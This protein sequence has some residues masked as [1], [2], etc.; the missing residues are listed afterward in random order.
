M[1]PFQLISVLV[2]LTALFAFLNRRFLRLPATIGVTL[3][4]LA[5][6]LLLLALRD[7][8]L[9]AVQAAQRLLHDLPFDEL[10]FQGLLSFLLFAGALG[11]NTGALLRQ[12]G[13]VLTFALVS[14]LLSV[15][16]VGAL[17]YWLLGLAGMPIPFAAALLFGAI[18]SPTDPV[19]VLDL[20]K[21]AKV[22]R[23]LE[24]LIA[25]ESLFNDGIGVVLFAVLASVALG[26]AGGQAVGGLE[27]L[28]LFAREALGG[29]AF[30]AA[31]GLGAAWLLRQVDDYVVEV[32]VTLAVVTGGYALAGALHVSGPLA[33]VVAGLIVGQVAERG[34]FSD[35]SRPR[36]EGFWHLTDEL[37]NVGLFVLIALEV[38]LVEFSARTLLLGLVCVPIVLFARA[39][40]VRLPLL[41]L[42]RRYAFSPFTSRIM[43]WGGLRG[44]IAVALAFSVP[45]GPLRTPFLVFT[46]V[47]VVFS[48]VVQG[49]SMERLARQASEAGAPEQ[50]S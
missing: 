26:G 44:G 31:L 22:P 12:G 30:G 18:I 6:A 7:T 45:P 27:V 1:T 16:L 38:A 13:A 40:S 14:T 36:V 39:V 8:G 35:H 42:R 20:L 32:L 15:L 10:L 33:M 2:T 19:A 21:R 4:G 9:P 34:L 41:A 29:V 49:L 28:G 3:I 17:V 46:Y 23:R 37:L 24:A 50:V 25:G 43:T 5:V 11:V 48:I 47:V